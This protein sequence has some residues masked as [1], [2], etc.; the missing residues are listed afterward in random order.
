M[1]FIADLHVHSKYSR[2]TSKQ[3]DLEHLYLAAQLKGI[4]LVGTGDAT[5]PAWF[6][7]IKEKLEP[8]EEGLFQLK[9]DL[10]RR[11]NQELPPMASGKV[12]FI[13]S[14]EISNIYKKDD[15]T[16]KNHNLVYFPD[17]DALA[18]FNRR[19]DKIGN[20]HSD[21]RPILGLD[22]RDLLELSLDT[23]E[24]SFLIP[25]HIWTPWFSVLGSKSG[26]DSIEE[27]YEDLTSHIFAVET[28]LSSDPLMNW[29]I[30]D[31]D[32]FTLVSNSDAHSPQKLGREAN[33][34]HTELNYE[35]IVN[36]L[37]TGDAEKC[38]G[39]LE[40]YPQEGKYHYDG[41][42]KCQVCLHPQ[43]TIAKK[44]ICPQCGKPVTLG[45]LYRVSQ[46]AD[47]PEGQQPESTLPFHHILPLCDILGNVL[48]VGPNSK[49]V[50]R[51]YD[52]ALQRLGPEMAILHALPSEEIGR[53]GIPLLKEAIVRMRQ[54]KIHVSPGYD[55]QFGRIEIFSEQERKEILGQTPLFQVSLDN[56][57]SKQK[58]DPGPASTGSASGHSENADRGVKEKKTERLNPEQRRAVDFGPGVL[59]ISAGPGTGKT[60][61]LSCRIRRLIRSNRVR[62]EHILAV[63]F[64]NKAAHEL[65]DRL[66]KDL[67]DKIKH[68]FIGTFHALCF[69]LLQQNES[70][71]RFC[72]VDDTDRLL[73]AS[74]AIRQTKR[75]DT[76]HTLLPQTVLSFIIKAKQLLLG[77]EDN[78]NSVVSSQDGEMLTGAY[79]IYQKLLSQQGLFDYEDLIFNVVRLFQQNSQ[80]LNQCRQRFRYVFI[81]EYQDLNY[82][83]YVLVK[84]ICP[85]DEKD[86]NLC[87]IGD[88][89]QSIY[90]FRGSTPRFFNRFL[91]DYPSAESIY[92]KRNYRSV[93]TILGASHQVLG[94]HR[95]DAAGTRIY[96][97]LEGCKTLTILE[98]PTAKAEAVAVARTIDEMVGGTGYHSLDTGIIR[99]SDNEHW[100]SYS[101]FAILYRTRAQGPVLAEAL[102]ASGI[103]VQRADKEHIIQ[104]KGIKELYSL[105]KNHRGIRNLVRFGAGSGCG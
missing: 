29:R 73:V 55:G 24:Q 20:I 87:V 13:L 76:A 40:F 66:T 15:R 94:T 72:I 9:P 83:Q 88:P 74:E 93:E 42:R 35:S 100:C 49:T 38:G 36:A 51:H 2:A 54:G 21:G 5:H 19:L 28:G 34:F 103:P 53:A 33:L 59:L 60:H 77:P 57:P 23:C 98:A 50:R 64:T 26:F 62:P 105:L 22:A 44:A 48:K 17:V 31:L 46:L 68:A 69:H 99:S 102:T 12:R 80:F 4:T 58:R 52:L 95:L 14:A 7:E 43:E 11:L 56:T 104:S 39:T 71:K 32:Q 8:A 84:L 91:M 18:A 79:K 70:H 97:N 10:T 45:V 16:R 25:A 67:P 1:S 82:A 85:P 27:C 30:S 92:L 61:T 75:G 37:K 6:A 90:G 81:D 63:T 101:D 65:A 47:R 3:L 96:S 86:T 78:L 41:H 89:D